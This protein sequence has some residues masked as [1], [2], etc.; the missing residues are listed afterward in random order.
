MLSAGSSSAFT[1]HLGQA[2]LRYTKEVETV[3][4]QEECLSETAILFKMTGQWS[5]GCVPCYLS[6]SLGGG[7]GKGRRLPS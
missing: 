7:C 5:P 2:E 3:P 1:S 6:G 4:M